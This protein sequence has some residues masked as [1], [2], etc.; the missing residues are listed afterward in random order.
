SSTK[1]VLTN[2]FVPAHHGGSSPL[3]STPFVGPFPTYR[4]KF[5][6]SPAN[7]IGSWLSQRPVWGSYQRLVLYC[8][9]VSGSSKRPVQPKSASTVPVVERTLPNG[10]YS[11]WAATVP[12]LSIQSRMLLRLSS[13][14]H[15]RLLLA[16]SWAS[17]RSTAGAHK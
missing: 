6:G 2:A 10:S 1:R 15:R 9:F 11:L 7:S 13:S 17:R 8:S 5:D 4:Y 3:G 12:V 14:A 16:S